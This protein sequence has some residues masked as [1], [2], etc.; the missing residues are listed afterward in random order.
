VPFEVQTTLAHAMETGQRRDSLGQLVARN[1]V[2]RF[3]ARFNGTLVVAL[4]LY[5]AIA[6]NPYLAF[7]LQV[8]GPGELTLD[9]TGDH[10]F[11][12]REIRQL[13]PT[14]A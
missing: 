3:E 14:A 10:G 5:P 8:N 6:A 4:D 12:H 13:V 7:W 11:A 9:W 2:T 1:I